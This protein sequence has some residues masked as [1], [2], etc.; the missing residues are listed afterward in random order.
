MKTTIPAPGG[1]G[2]VA[3]ARDAETRRRLA[4]EIAMAG[5]YQTTGESATS[6]AGGWINGIG[7]KDTLL[8]G[9]AHLRTFFEGI[10]WWHLEPATL[11]LADAEVFALQ[12]DNGQ[13]VILYFPNGTEDASLPPALTG[14]KNVTWFNPHTGSFAPAPDTQG[15]WACSIA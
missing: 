6:G 1:E 10:E 11:T 15:D 13:A 8:I 2:R 4:W 12:E 3:P 5:G 9:L 14:G 7:D